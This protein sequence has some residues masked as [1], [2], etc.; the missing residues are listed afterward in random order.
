MKTYQVKPYKKFKHVITIA[1]KLFNK[2]Q[3]HHIFKIFIKKIKYKKKL[4]KVKLKK[5]FFH[6]NFCKWN[7]TKIMIKEN[8]A[9]E[10]Q[11]FHYNL[12]QFKKLTL[13]IQRVKT[14]LKDKI[15]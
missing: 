7:Q 9:I 4:T 3:A 14:K 5:M 15:L 12:I 8:S 13:K 11:N 2:F 6:Y 1:L 10:V